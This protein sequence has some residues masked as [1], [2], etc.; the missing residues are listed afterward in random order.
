MLVKNKRLRFA[1]EGKYDALC[2]YNCLMNTRFA[3][4]KNITGEI[5]STLKTR[6]QMLFPDGNL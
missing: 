1:G 4:H 2:R 6:S 3:F 5:E